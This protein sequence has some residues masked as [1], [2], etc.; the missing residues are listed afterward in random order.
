M[1]MNVDSIIRQNRLFFYSYINHICILSS[2]DNARLNKIK[3]RKLGEIVLYASM[4]ALEPEERNEFVELIGE[5]NRDVNDIDGLLSGSQ[6]SEHDPIVNTRYIERL[7][8]HELDDERYLNELRTGQTPVVEDIVEMVVDDD[9]VVSPVPEEI[10]SSDEVTGSEDDDVELSQKLPKIILKNSEN[11]VQSIATAC[12]RTLIETACLLLIF[13]IVKV[14]LKF[15]TFLADL[16]AKLPILKQFNELGGTIY[17][18]LEG[19]FIVFIGFAVISLIAPMLD[20]SI[21]QAINS[22][23]LGSICYNNNLLLKIIM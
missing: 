10:P 3:G 9:I 17:G 15:V 16:I 23:L 20:S 13:V 22:S 7:S 19:L 21:L 5:I 6:S 8:T 12:S 2:M 1:I 18:L 4:I 11:T 14:A